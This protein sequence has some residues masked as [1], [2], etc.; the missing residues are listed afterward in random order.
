[1]DVFTHIQSY[2]WQLFDHDNVINKKASEFVFT[3]E[4]HVIRLAKDLRRDVNREFG[5]GSQR[6]DW[7]CKQDLP[8]ARR[9][10]STYTVSGRSPV[11]HIRPAIIRVHTQTHTHTHTHEGWHVKVSA[12][13]FVH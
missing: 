11:V 1:M 3:T 12:H 13:M 4:G 10:Q 2:L 5:I 8:V 6:G 7:T 9:N